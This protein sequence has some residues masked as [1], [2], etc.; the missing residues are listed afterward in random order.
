MG[1]SLAWAPG[2]AKALF[3]VIAR[4]EA[5]KQSSG[6]KLSGLLHFVGNDERGM[7]GSRRLRL[8]IVLF[9]GLQEAV[10]LDPEPDQHRRGNVDRGIRA[11]QDA[12]E[13]RNGEAEDHLRTYQHQHPE[14]D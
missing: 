9:V 11:D 5:T 1:T 10:G 7:N 13:D 6:V 12:E 3:L 8:G 2:E 4:S 14:R